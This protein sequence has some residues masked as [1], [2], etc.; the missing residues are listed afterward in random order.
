MDILDVADEPVFDERIVKYEMHTYNPYANT[1]LG[2]SDE[3]RIPIQQQDLYTLPF[4]SFL[5]IEGKLVTSPTA[6]GGENVCV[7]GNNCAAF[8]FDEMRYELDGVEI[9]R[10]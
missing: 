6:N 2:Y 8:L 1:T 4:E 7:M 3:I 9:D 5:Y 10:N